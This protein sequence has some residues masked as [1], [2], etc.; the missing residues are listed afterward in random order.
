MAVKHLAVHAQLVER[1]EDGCI[2]IKTRCRLKIGHV[3]AHS[4]IYKAIAQHIQAAP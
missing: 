1:I 3:K 4:I 2:R